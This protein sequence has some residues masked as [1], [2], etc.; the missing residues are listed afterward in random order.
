MTTGSGTVTI[1]CLL[2]YCVT[3]SRRCVKD[4]TA[5]LHRRASHWYEQAGQSSEAIQH[6]IDAQITKRPFPSLKLMP[7][8]CSCS[9]TRKPS[10][11]GWK[12]F[13]QNG[14]LKV[15]KTNLAFAWMNL[16]TGKFAAAMP[17]IGRLQM[18]FSDDELDEK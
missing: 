2:I 1:T 4:G 16:F 9:G 13:R 8:T 18:M 7:W 6:A 15:P 3:G 11:S 5:E 10:Q 12:P 14:Q 17:Y